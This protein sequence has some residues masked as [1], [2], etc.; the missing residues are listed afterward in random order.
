MK[1]YPSLHDIKEVSKVELLDIPLAYIDTS[2]TEQYI[3]ITKEPIFA[4]SYGESLIKAYEEF[5][6]LE[7][8]LFDDTNK[9]IKNQIL[10]RLG[11]QYV[12]EPQNAVEFTPLRFSFDA[13]VK[14]NMTFT[15]DVHYNL[16]VAASEEGIDLA[17]SKQL[18]SVFG[19]APRRGLCP[20]NISIND[21]GMTPET[22]INTSFKGNDFIFIKSPDGVQFREITTDATTGAEIITLKT[23]DV[24]AL[25]DAN[26]NVWLS[27]DSFSD[28]LKVKDD[29]L[30]TLSQPVLYAT[31]DYAIKDYTHYFDTSVDHASYPRDKYSYSTP[32]AESSAVMILEKA[33]G[34]F[35]ILTHKTFFDNLHENVKLLYEIMMQ[36]FLK[37]YYRTKTFSS[38]ITDQPVD[39]IAF[40]SSKY[41]LQHDEI[42]LNNLLK[43]N[44]Y[45]INGEYNLLAVNVS[46]QDVIFA[47]MNP[48]KDLFFCKV[49]LQPDPI[50]NDGDIS[51][52]TSR[53]SVIHYRQAVIKKIESGLS[54]GTEITESGLYVTIHPCH[55]TQYRINTTNDLTLRIENPKFEYVL[56]CKTGSTDIE[57]SFVL[58]RSVNYTVA[59]GLKVAT[60]KV[61]SK[62]AAK[63]FDIRING[64]GLPLDSDPNYDMLDIGHINGRPYR[65][66][67]TLIIR[68]P[69][70]LKEHDAK[71]RKTLEKHSSSGDYPVII[72]R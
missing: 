2:N 58:I 4:N 65:V 56:C 9:I 25:L 39:Y 50:K 41:N 13:L 33:N 40:K 52:Y 23:L 61:I 12:Y 43:N 51:V 24:D 11:N 14:K 57:N 8:Y 42:N 6:S 27:V 45:N 5:N 44:N 15:N 31:K 19:D 38:W 37:S 10:K 53:H 17:F 34:G 26:V 69:A 48:Q 36:V 67:S 46:G 16:K 72:Y 35:V 32:F 30:F 55:S 28:T 20:A 66:G 64:G 29:N 62:P 21:L 63:T 47:N 59:D 49:N 3:S 68:L 7:A 18:I 70:R 60:I 54:I 1:I 71:I 22:L